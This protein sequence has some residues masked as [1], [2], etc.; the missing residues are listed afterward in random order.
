MKYKDNKCDFQELVYSTTRAKPEQREED[1]T[2]S[3]GTN[4][5]SL[6]TKKTDS[7][8]SKGL[9]LKCSP[10][11]L[12]HHSKSTG[13]I[14]SFVKNKFDELVEQLDTDA[15]ISER[16]MLL[17][18]VRHL[19]P[20]SRTAKCNRLTRGGT[21]V[22]VLK[23]TEYNSVNFSGLQTCGSPWSCPWCSS[24]ISE[25]RKNEVVQ[26]L[27]S[28]L[29]KNGT[30]Y[31]ITLTFR[32]TK[33]Q[34][35]KQL[36][37][38]QTKALAYFRNS[39]TYKKYL[40]LIGY[41]GLIRALEVTWGISNGWHP[42]THEIVFADNKVSFQSIKRLLFPAWVSACIKVGL[43]APSFKRGIDIRGGEK[44]GDYV[45]K[46]GNELTKSH[47]K[48][49]KGDR[50]SPFDLLRS[51]FF[52]NVKLHGAKFVQFSE[53]MQGSR[54][55][56]WTN[57]LKDKFGITDKIDKDLADEIQESAYS[58]GN[59]TLEKW[60]SIVRYKSMST[61]RIMF[62]HYHPDHVFSYIDDLYS[63]YIQTGDKLE[64]DQRIE[65]NRNKYKKV[66]TLPDQS[67]FLSKVDNR[68]IFDKINEKM[69]LDK[70]SINPLLDPKL[71]DYIYNLRQKI[72][73]RE[74]D[75]DFLINN[76]STK[77]IG[78]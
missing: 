53:G 61:V 23:N 38:L 57:G 24:K 76:Y 17:S 69:V 64:D 42:H 67:D 26:A 28:H 8:D 47:F 16:Y 45:N 62:S 14:T 44:A 3:L 32:H 43:S 74:K 56:Y 54:Q 50:F 4:A 18:S 33:E 68:D 9:A 41:T 35:L 6:H 31:F 40:Q 71:Y 10:P 52:D 34:D 11:V 15:L 21:D 20:F 73:R 12:T 48:K 36:R 13:L 70:L 46:Y 5:K 65:K 29:S 78:N 49:A 25:R 59:I 30:L 58:L 63:R 27:D 19:M 66:N 22:T 72:N 55:L 1:Y 60:R 51:Y 39:R 37:D 2:G 75:N 7:L 77:K